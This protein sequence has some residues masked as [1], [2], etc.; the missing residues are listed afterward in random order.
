MFCSDSNVDQRY[1]FG[2]TFKNNSVMHEVMLPRPNLTTLHFDDNLSS[3]QYISNTFGVV[4][5]L[6]F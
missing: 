1:N 6:T 2:E 3:L 5:N 4:V